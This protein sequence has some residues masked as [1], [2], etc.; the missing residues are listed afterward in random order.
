MKFVHLKTLRDL[1][2]LVASSPS[3]NVIQHLQNGEFHLYFIIGGTLNEIFLYFVR[4]A[5]AIEGKF[6]TYNSYTG[7]IGSSEKVAKEPNQNSFPL[8]EIENQDLLPD[9]LLSKVNNL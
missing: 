8:V 2:M 6:V 3:M 1:I 4:E 5:E 7:E 9:D